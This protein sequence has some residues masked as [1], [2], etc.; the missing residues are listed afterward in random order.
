MPDYKKMYFDLSAKVADAIEILIQAQ[1]QA[2]KEYSED[3]T[4][5]ISFRKY[6]RL[7][8]WVRKDEDE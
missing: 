4:P 7:N 3:T 1:C 6:Y 5:L 8:D 2:E